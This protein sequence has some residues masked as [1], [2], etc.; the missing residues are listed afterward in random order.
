VTVLLRNIWA[1]LQD[2]GKRMGMRATECIQVVRRV[3][4]NMTRRTGR[5]GVKLCSYE[6]LAA[7]AVLA[8]V[9]RRPLKATE[10]QEMGGKCLG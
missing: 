7:D 10:K 5:S 9:K 2:L 1:I 3:D 4:V 8:G 6:G